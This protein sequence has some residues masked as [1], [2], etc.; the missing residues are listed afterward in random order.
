MS[1][2]VVKNPLANHPAP[3]DRPGAASATLVL[4]PRPR[5]TTLMLPGP[6]GPPAAAPLPLLPGPAGPLLLPRPAGK[7]SIKS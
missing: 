4:L 2:C 1:V 6:A 7:K 5:W 3:L